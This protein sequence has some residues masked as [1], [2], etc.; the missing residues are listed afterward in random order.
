MKATLEAMKNAVATQAAKD[1]ATNNVRGMDTILRHALYY[2]TGDDSTFKG[3]DDTTR[4]TL[5][6]TYVATILA[7]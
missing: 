6:A 1:F 2:L 7:E 3:L 4:E 5:R